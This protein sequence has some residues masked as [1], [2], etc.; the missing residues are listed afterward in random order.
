M[1]T[2]W[3]YTVDA[4]PPMVDVDTFDAATGNRWY[5]DERTEAALA[6][7]SAAIRNVSG[8]HICPSLDC[9]ATITARGKVAKIPAK[10]VTAI[11]SVTEDGV[12]LGA[13]Q[14][15]ARHDGLLR[16]CQFRNW[17][18][19]WD[20]IVVS[21]EAGYEVDAVPDLVAAVVQVA[22]AVLAVPTG[23]ASESAGGVSVSYSTAAASV[24][25]SMTTQ[26]VDALAPY[27]LV[28]SHAA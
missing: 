28:S 1:H 19:T 27:R 8:W 25:A 15:E 26:L 2:P 7:A 4:L 17:T 16:R 10:L 23:V 13:G 22:E 11:E 18:P 14:F 24:A 9:T 12:E 6:A 5:G 20:G 21:Y 3:G